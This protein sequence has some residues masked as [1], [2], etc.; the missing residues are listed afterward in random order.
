MAN[1]DKPLVIFQHIPRTGGTS[2]WQILRTYYR[3]KRVIRVEEGTSDKNVI[4]LTELFKNHA[5]DYDVIGGHMKHFGLHVHSPRPTTYVTMLR[6]PADVVLSR[7][8]KILRKP[9]K[10]KHELF[11]N[12]LGGD[13]EKALPYMEN[14]TTLLIRELGST[15]D[16]DDLSNDEMLAN[17]K[18][19]LEEHFTGIGILER[20]DESVRVMSVRHNWGRY[21]PPPHKNSGSNRPKKI[22]QEIY[23]LLNEQCKHDLELYYFANDLLTQRLKEDRLRIYFDMAKYQ[24]KRIVKPS[25]KP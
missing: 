23:E 9:D 13:F 24:V 22:S 11:A 2:L 10:D 20:Y 1:T 16:A 12:E 25:A 8:Y 21:I 3:P 5:Y 17:A 18:R 19:N 4:R 14:D 15:G 6:Y 7:F